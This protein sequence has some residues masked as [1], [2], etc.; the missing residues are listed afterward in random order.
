[1][2][3]RIRVWDLPTRL[4]H[5]ALVACVA[6]LFLTSYVPGSWLEWHARLGYTVVALLL[7]RLLWGFVGGR[8]S[9]FAAFLYGPGSV[10][11][12]LRGHPHPDHLI[13]HN[14]LGAV[15][16]FAMLGVLLAQ[17]ATG[18][19]SDDESAFTGPLNRFIS[20]SKGL[21]ATWYHKQVGQW[22]LVALI[23][24][25]LL[26]VL[27]YVWG[28]KQNL[29]GPMVHGDKVTSHAAAGSR[30]DAAS[31]LLALLVFA[32]CAGAVAWLVR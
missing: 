7:F 15:S 5:W 21:A 29:V 16:V 17:A 28:K 20:T 12:Y 22:L 10:G 25:H 13:G 3:D 27:Y 18:L 14:P 23:V 1:M 9:R 11:A 31:R 8:W 26:A 19:V 4:F 30:D 2:A 6:G 32:A 24:L